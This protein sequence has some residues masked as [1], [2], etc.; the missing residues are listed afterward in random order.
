MPLILAKPGWSRR[1]A[2]AGV[3]FFA[4]VALVVFVGLNVLHGDSCS[5]AAP[6][7]D[8]PIGPGWA[9]NSVNAVIFRTHS[10][11]TFEETQYASY[12]DGNSSVIVARRQLG[13]MDWEVHNTGLRGNTR[14]AHNAICIGVDG[15]GFLHLSWDHHSH[16][17]KYRRSVAPGVFKFSEP[18]PM[19]GEAETG[20][21]YPE[22]Y[23]HPDGGFVFM[24]RHGASG[25]GN[26]MLNRYEVSTK[27]WTAVQH[28]LIDG[29]GQRNAYTNQL[30]IDGRG[31]WHLSW[32][33]RGTHDVATNHNI[34]YATS[35]D[36][37]KSWF[38]STG[39]KYALPITYAT[40]EI[41]AEVPPGSELINQCSMSVDSRGNPMIA[42]YWRTA[43][44]DIPQ[45]HLTW[46]DGEEWH[47]S[48]VSRRTTAFR[49]GGGGT[50][51]IPISRP[52][53]AVAEDDRVF[54]IFRDEE[55]GSRISVAISEDPLRE[56][57]SYIDL[58][59]VSVGMW[60][61]TYDTELWRRD[62]RLHLFKQR[63]GQGQSETLQE[64]E[65]QMVSIL[66][67]DPS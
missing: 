18:L 3:E 43:E 52:Q 62:N 64:V 56:T 32:T 41:V 37:G 30:A 23:N 42:S 15:E 6:V 40:A 46:F 24:Y 44:S 21:T 38:K 10:V 29:E 28:P 9:K 50:R 5:P 12:Y 45:Y 31:R 51:R 7:R 25:Q 33:W 8:V 39:E 35:P 20:V 11:T 53:V 1:T 22:F 19:T 49:L 13:S 61:P 54:M 34:L 47:I 2:V 66:E 60:E 55:R 59:E 26:T 36:D 14:D 4:T 48:Q 16:P 27:K 17:L 57:W 65:P 67:W 63:V 58:T